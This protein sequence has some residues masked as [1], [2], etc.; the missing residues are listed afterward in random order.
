MARVPLPLPAA[1]PRS[2]R[3]DADPS[4]HR[5]TL[6]VDAR[7]PADPAPEALAILLPATSA[8]ARPDIAADARAIRIPFRWLGGT[9]RAETWRTEGPV[10]RS[11]EDLGGARVSESA[12]FQFGHLVCP[13]PPT[14]IEDATSAAYRQVLALGMRS[15]YPHLLRVWNYFSAINEGDGDRERYRRF[16]VGRARA[17]PAEPA[18]GY[19]AATAIG[20]PGS[21]AELHLS[22][23]A[24]RRPGVP[25]ENPRQVSAWEYPR[26]YGP[27]APGFSRAMLLEWNDP[28]L[29]LVSGTAS[30]VGH[31]SRHD[32]A[33][34]QLDEALLNLDHVLARAAAR[35]GAPSRVGAGTLLRVYVRDPAD[36]A[37]IH[38]RLLGRLG[39]ATP[40]MLLHGDI[41]RRELLVELEAVHAF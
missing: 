20:M 31:E 12:D 10:E 40:F 41:C 28:P 25:I 5:P 34:A 29:L 6:A 7:S 37:A 11:A 19:A 14:G 1:T 23:L 35:L 36:A 32:E 18:T 3:R 39:A 33:I 24:A 27:V 4:P 38:A 30:V 13:L 16:C 2:S 26:E 8:V 9:S 15:G 22:W 17:I 21:G